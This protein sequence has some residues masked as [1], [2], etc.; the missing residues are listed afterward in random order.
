MSRRAIT[1]IRDLSM[2]NKLRFSSKRPGMN[3]LRLFHLEQLTFLCRKPNNGPVF[4]TG[5]RSLVPQKCLYGC[6]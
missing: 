1:S 4:G 5:V 3:R 2:K 6:S